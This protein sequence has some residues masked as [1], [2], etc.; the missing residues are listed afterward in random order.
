MTDC[1]VGDIVKV[2]GLKG[3]PELNGSEGK[4]EKWVQE[5][6]RWEVRLHSMKP[7]EAPLGLKAGN[8]ER[9]A[10]Q[11]T[12]LKSGFLSAGFQDELTSWPNQYRF[13]VGTEV[14]CRTGGGWSAGTIVKLDYAESGWPPGKTVPYQVQIFDGPLIYVPA[15]DDRVCRKLTQTWWKKAFPESARVYANDNPPADSL[16]KKK[17]YRDVNEQDYLGQTALM[18]A[19]KKEW[20]NAILQLIETKA[21]LDIARKDQTRAIHI[22][23]SHGAQLLKLLVDARADLN[24]QDRDPDYDPSF[25]STTFEDRLEHRTPLHHLCAAGDA[26]AAKLVLEAKAKVDI[27]DSQWKTALHL[28]IDEEQNDCIDLL[29]CFAADTNLGNQCSGMSNSPLMDAA[30]AGNAE[31]VRKLM[32]ARA[33]INQKGKQ[34]MS[35]LHLAAR[36]RRA[37]V[38]EFLLAAGA[39]MNEQS[40]VGTALQLA[41]KNGGADLFKVFGVSSEAKAPRAENIS[42]LDASQRAALFLS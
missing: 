39:D 9:V 23:V 33:D 7:K 19:V 40:C 24:V 12:K 15:D 27:R 11:P 5:K 34:Q 29:L 31:F 13:Q 4:L 37:Q 8:I 3:R 32:A 26:A 2:V 38:A 42:D 25:I 28:A 17:R 10:Q 22:A 18:E 41:H 35:A 1:R 14:E 16:V 6:Q 20:P 36:N 30:A 21:D